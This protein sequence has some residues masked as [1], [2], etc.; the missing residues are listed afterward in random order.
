MH[1]LQQGV[2]FRLVQRGLDNACFEKG[3]ESWRARHPEAELD[4]S[5]KET[6]Y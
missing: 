6:A 1:L 3:L 5:P 2:T 4:A